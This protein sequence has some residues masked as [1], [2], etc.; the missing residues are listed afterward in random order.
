MGPSTYRENSTRWHNSGQY[1]YRSIM[2]GDGMQVAIDTRDNKTVYTGY[3]FGNYS[4]INTATEDYK[5]I[6][7]KHELGERPLRWNWQAPIHLSV[8]N[9]DILYMGSNKLHRSFNQGD[10]FEA[11]SDDL[12]TGGKKGDVAYSTLTSIHESPLQFGLL[13][14]G[15]DDG[16][17]H[18]TKDNGNNWTK[19]TTGLP[20]DMWVTKVQ[21]SSFKKE[22]VYLSMNGYRWDDFN[23][24]LYRS[25]DYGATWE[26]I[27][28]DLP[29]EPINVVE[30]DPHKEHIVY[31]GTDHGLYVSFNKGDSFMRME[32][33]LPAVPVH[34]L[35]VHPREHDLVVGTHG[36]SFYVANVNELQAMDESMF[37]KVIHIFSIKPVY[38]SSRWGS[39]W[40]K[41]RDASEPKVEIPIYLKSDGDVK[42]RI[43]TKE[44][45]LLQS[46]THK[47]TKGINYVEYDLSLTESAVKKYEKS[48]NE[49][50]KKDEDTIEVEK[51]DTG[52]YY[53]YKGKYEL[54]VAKDGTTE[55]GSLVVKERG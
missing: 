19:I 37:E 34:D 7:P 4:R 40:S 30:E 54:E 21:A 55:T 6:T 47:G 48:L 20:K 46:M 8:H 43:K 11:I 10:D 14:V 38:W 1:P 22:R 36:R 35:V 41:W 5:Y 15:S 42:I 9:Q 53:L 49:K 13:Y 26:K 44:G 50:L 12:T 23:S 33:G 25:D 27:G 2:G 31:V 3:Q 39:S 51:K 29:P 16:L 24:Y 17:V 45:Q 52:K 32:G 28:T 18:V